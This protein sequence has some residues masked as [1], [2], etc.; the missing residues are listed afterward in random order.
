MGLVE[1]WVGQNS[2]F[3]N[4]DFVQKKL[5]FSL[6]LT[7]LSQTKEFS[8][9]KALPPI[10]WHSKNNLKSFI[11]TFNNYKMELHSLCTMTIPQI[12]L[13][14]IVDINLGMSWRG[15]LKGKFQTELLLLTFIQGSIQI[16]ILEVLQQ[17]AFNKINTWSARIW[18]RSPEHE[19]TYLKWEHKSDK[20][21]LL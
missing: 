3:C 6:F 12:K 16:F 10:L 7:G 8:L 13:A 19:L 11:D 2:L 18:Y 14:W 17:L 20:R 1:K 15:F 9:K 21:T 4:K 5:A